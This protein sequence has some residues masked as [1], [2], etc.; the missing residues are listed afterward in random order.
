[1]L[2]VFVG[3]DAREDEAYRVCQFSIVSRASKPVNIVPM[4][5]RE[6]RRVGLFDRPWRIDERGQYFDERDGKPFSTEFSHS[7]FL[8]PAYAAQLGISQ[9]W[10]LFCDCDFL[11]Q[12]DIANL[13]AL[14]DPAY[15]VMVVKHTH[16]PPEGLKMDGVAQLRYRRKNWSSLVLWNLGH[17]ANDQMTASL[18]NTLAGSALHAF[19]WLKNKE[20]GTL[21][22]EWNFLVG[23]TKATDSAIKALHFTDSGPWMREPRDDPDRLWINEQSRMKHPR[24]TTALKVVA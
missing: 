7:R 4:K 9:G 23:Y 14:A 21:P 2:N 6:L 1:M 16:K 19:G 8:V 10:V 22:Q 18:A 12:A 5:H 13:F 11:F 24:P 15:A 20:I 17:G 3:Y